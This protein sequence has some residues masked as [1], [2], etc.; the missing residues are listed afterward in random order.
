VERLRPILEGASRGERKCQESLYKEFY[1]YGM[2]VCLRYSANREEAVEI[3][4]D[5]FMNVFKNLGQFDS[6]RPFTPWFRKIVINCALNHYKQFLKYSNEVGLE[7]IPEFPDIQISALSQLEYSDLIKVIQSLP[8][9][10][11]TVFNLYVIEGYG[12]T[13]IAELLNISIG[14]SKSNLFRAREKLRMMLTPEN[15]E[16]AYL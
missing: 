4:H 15:H 2:S 7:S 13:E 8:L 5:G 1:G 6:N 11:R 14:T 12:H 3:L 10:Y 9:A 16:K